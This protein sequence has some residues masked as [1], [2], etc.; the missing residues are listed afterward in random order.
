LQR[1]VCALANPSA[2]DQL[3]KK[4]NKAWLNASACDTF[5][6]WGAP[7]T[8]TKVLLATAMCVNKPEPSIGT[9]ASSSP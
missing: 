9:T 2:T 3:R 8:L 5:M 6:P 1:E 7:G 4:V